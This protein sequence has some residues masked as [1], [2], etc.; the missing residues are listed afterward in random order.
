MKRI[1]A[2]KDHRMPSLLSDP[3]ASP[4]VSSWL[5]IYCVVH[6]HLALILI[7]A[8]LQFS[9]RLLGIISC[10]EDVR[11]QRKTEGFH[12][13][14]SYCDRHGSYFKNEFSLALWQALLD[15]RTC[16]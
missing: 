12:F 5:V 9:N 1:S 14:I 10:N 4:Q 2:L 7:S 16:S 11:K 6:R 13:K 15:T 3:L 8:G